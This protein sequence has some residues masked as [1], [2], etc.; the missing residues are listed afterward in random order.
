MQFRLNAVRFLALTAVLS[1]ATA[2]RAADEA[3][4][5]EKMDPAGLEFFEKNVRPIF[6]E[7][8]YKCHSSAE[9]VSKGGLLMDTRAGLLSGGDQGPAVVP[10]DLKKSLLLVAVHQTDPELSMPP[11]KEGAKLSD[12]QISV[13]EEWVKMGA[14]APV[15]SGGA[16]LT[17]LSQKARDHWA[18]KPVG[19]YPVPTKLSLPG[20][21]QT[22]ID[23]FVM[24]KLDQLGLKP[25][26][27]ADGEALLRRLS[28][29]LIGLPPSN[30][31]VEGFSREYDTAVA[32]D[33]LSLRN[34]QPARSATAVVER[35]VDRLLA[36]PHY[37]ERWARHWLDTAR[38][39]DTKGL[40]R[41]GGIENFESSWTYRDYVIDAFN[42]DKPY[43]QFIIE[44]LAADRLPDL[45]KDDPRLAALGFITLGKRFQN[46]DDTIDERI[47]ATTKG[48]LGLTV[49]CARCHDHKFDPIPA[50][51]YY[52]LHGIFS[53][54]GEPMQ[55]P[56][57]RDPLL[58]GKN[59]PTNAYRADFDKKHAD[60]IN[61]TG[62][63][64]YKHIAGLMNTFHKEFGPR[65]LVSL[66][67]GYRS[68]AGYDI[69]KKYDMQ[70]NR[71]IDGSF[72]VRADSP[73]TGP[74]ARLKR[75]NEKT[76]EKDAP[77]A[78]AEA[79]ADKK[80]PVNP[81]IAEALRTLKPR[82]LEEVALAYQSVLL[83]NHDKI[84][85]HIQLRST[86]G[87]KGDKDDAAMAQLASYP[88]P[89]PNIEDINTVP[90]LELLTEARTFCEA[91]QAAPSQT[92]RNGNKPAKYFK[93][94]E[95]NDL[96]ITHKGG[97]GMAMVVTDNE[98]PRDSYVYIRGDRNK[99]GAVTPR[100]FLEILAGPDRLPF[101]EGSGRRELALSIASRTN[102]LTSRVLV[103][104][105]WLHHFGAGIVSTPDDLGNMSEKPT[106]PEL[107]DWLA[108]NFV[109]NGWSIK[110]MHKKILL[111]AAYRQ[112]ANPN[113]NSQVA[114][115]GAVDPFKVD[116]SNKFI[117]H[118]N[119]RR[120]DFESIRDSML[121]LSGKL[122][123]ALGGRA[124]NI[125]DEPYSYRRTI[126]GF[127]DR[128]RLSELQTQFDFAD[129]DM[130]NTKRSTTIVP[131]QALFFMNNPLAIEVARNVTSRPELLK[132]TS[133]SE[134]ISQ[135]YRI[136]YQRSPTVPEMK[137]A[138][139]FIARIAGYIDEPAQAA[140]PAK[141]V[142]RLAK[143]KEAKA[144]AKAAG[145]AAI[146]ASG[147]PLQPATVAV[148]E[149]K[150]ETEVKGGKIVNKTEMV[151]RKEPS[152]PWVMLAQS[153]ICSNEFV[154]LN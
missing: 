143:A 109:E 133:D 44:Q 30:S 25:S 39:S 116:S 23:A 122:D 78:I 88:W 7:R 145:A 99:R 96:D 35:A 89:L 83:K 138:S 24:S 75:V 102:P 142:D 84:L 17:G 112:S 40:R 148:P 12:K 80:N 20:W 28:Y 49:A 51:D 154:Y 9:G 82:S 132:A 100:Q 41:N 98:K 5:A 113:T 131:Q 38:Y 42:T 85:A 121:V 105:L 137:V 93:F 1:V 87:R 16:K 74:L 3:K 141:V 90:A 48:F 115:K 31:E 140:A 4:P 60:L 34:G 18:F 37:G 2:A 13:L 68:T 26:P 153:M 91:W 146:A 19:E 76:F 33:V 15:G 32:R 69:L 11:R 29:D 52:S 124:V 152:N 56:V 58:Q 147:K 151:S 46:A 71:E 61:E 136:M 110:K 106:H 111:S 50:A 130:A 77:A 120:L 149:V 134:R 10:G 22:E 36:S 72:M 57:I 103:N 94:K 79:L 8:C 127:I 54:I 101:Y 107:L 62:R 65:A 73:I 114:Q 43:D 108:T 70:E 119:L 27:A 66:V 126:Y 92:F 128:D 21:C 144:K 117:W 135:L 64:Y 97:P 95:L 81:I 104:R 14:P 67:G 53:S 123:R 45:A 150:L 55:Y 63:G 125:T 6:T 129:P 118:A 86:P 47:D 59:A 139:E